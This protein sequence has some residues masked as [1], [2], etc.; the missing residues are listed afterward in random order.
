MEKRTK[1]KLIDDELVYFYELLYEY[2]SDDNHKGYNSRFLSKDLRS[3]LKNKQSSIKEPKTRNTILYSGSSVIKDFLRHLR[4]AV[5][6]C[7][8]KSID[9]T[10][11][12]E[13]YDEYQGRCTMAGSVSKTIFYQLIKEIR[14]TRKQ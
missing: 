11:T 14:K 7:N 10:N 13:F 3:V 9:S 2:E 4:N 1:S 5:A 12:F 6:H 8:V